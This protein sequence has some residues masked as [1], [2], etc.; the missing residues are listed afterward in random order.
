M[1]QGQYQ[2]GNYVWTQDGAPCH[3]GK[4]MHKFCKAK[5]ADFW[6]VDFWPSSSR[7]LNSLDYT[8]WGVL[9]QTTNKTSHS[10]ISSFKAAIEEEWGKMTKDFVVKSCAAFWCRVEAVI[11][12]KG[13]D[14]E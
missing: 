11:E 8:M 6:P 9:E 4:K 10:N 5:F 12:C 2:E 7:D 14:I 3:T 13:S 1:A